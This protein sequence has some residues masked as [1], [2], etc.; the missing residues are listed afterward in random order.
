MSSRRRSSRRRQ[1]RRSGGENGHDETA[2]SRDG[3]LRAAIALVGRHRF[4]CL[5]VA[6]AVLTSAAYAW[7]RHP[8]YQSEDLL[9]VRAPESPGA[10]TAVPSPDA[11]PPGGDNPFARLGE[12]ELVE[13]V[14]RYVE[15]D[16]VRSRLVGAGASAD[17]Q[18]ERGV[19]SPLPG[20]FATITA[21]AP[22]AA[23]AIFTADRVSQEFRDSLGRLQA[24]AGV[25]EPDRLV[26]EVVAPQDDVRTVAPSRNRALVALFLLG[27]LV[28]LVGCATLDRLFPPRR[29]GTRPR[30][31]SEGL[32]D[33]RPTPRSATGSESVGW[34]SVGRWGRFGRCG[35]R[36]RWRS[37]R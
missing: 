9:V 31:R 18:V 29:R 35:R 19:D 4:V 5:L 17:Y 37:C 14:S 10:A 16:A 11:V 21:S 33:L 8:Q 2:S 22:D 36:C 7:S 25:A 12:T 15:S 20:A 13:A 1:S 26:A 24:Q 28:L 3:G 30:A 32:P 34:W 6:G 23:Q 27:A